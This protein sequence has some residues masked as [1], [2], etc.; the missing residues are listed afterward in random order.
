[1]VPTPLNVIA[2]E[3]D[4]DPIIDVQCNGLVLHEVLVD[5][6]VGI[7][8]MTILAM[9]FLRLKIDKPTSIIFKIV[10]KRVVKPEW[11][12]NNVVIIVMR[13]STILDFHVILEDDGAY[14]MIL[15]RPWLTKSHAKNYWGEGYMTIGIHPNW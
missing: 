7:N 8:V 12:I 5:G 10:N 3:C 14:P 4:Y 11:I 6:G 2:A 15:G 13:V 9:R 1:M